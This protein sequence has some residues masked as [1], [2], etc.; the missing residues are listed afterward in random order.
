MVSIQSNKAS[1]ID[2]KIKHLIA[3]RDECNS[4]N[5]ISCINGFKFKIF[6]DDINSCIITLQLTC[7]NC[8]FI[9]KSERIL[10]NHKRSCIYIK[11]ERVIKIKNKLLDR[12]YEKDLID[13]K[14]PIDNEQDSER[15]QSLK[16]KNKNQQRYTDGKGY[17]N[18]IICFFITIKPAHCGVD[19]LIKIIDFINSTDY[20]PELLFYAFEQRSDNVE[21]MGD[22]AHIHAIVKKSYSASVTKQYLYQATRKVNK[23][24]DCV[25]SLNCIDVVDIRCSEHLNNVINYMKGIK[26]PEKMPVCNLNVQWRAKFNIR[27]FYNLDEKHVV[28][29]EQVN[30]TKFEN[31]VC[32]IETCGNSKFC[33]VVVDGVKHRLPIV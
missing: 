2:E 13:G 32:L 25:N 3:L 4:T 21:N 27:P 5:N 24:F 9:A 33:V 14:I 30:E 19:T 1:T 6:V 18:H 10:I 20:A 31:S 15:I 23:F 22:G 11:E 16:N 26:T 7:K 17:K 29:P 28:I 8:G 12:A